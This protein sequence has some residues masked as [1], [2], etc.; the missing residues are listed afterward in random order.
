MR[1]FSEKYKAIIWP[2][3][4]CHVTSSNSIHK[5]AKLRNQLKAKHQKRIMQKQGWDLKRWIEEVGENYLIDSS[6]KPRILERGEF[7][8][9]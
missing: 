4:G 2:C 7:L 6:G 1:K 9:E 3:W 8:W 5:N